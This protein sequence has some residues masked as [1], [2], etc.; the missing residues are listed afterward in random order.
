MPSSPLGICSEVLPLG[1]PRILEV[2]PSLCCQPF[3]FALADC[4][5]LRAT[6]RY[7]DRESHH[8]Y[9]CRGPS[10][11]PQLGRIY[12]RTFYRWLWC[13]HRFSCRPCLCVGN[14]TP[15]PSGPHDSY[16]QLLLVYRRHTGYVHP[17][18]DVQIR[19]FDRMAHSYMA[20]TGQRGSRCVS[21]FVP[22]RGKYWAL[23]P[24]WI[25]PVAHPFASLLDG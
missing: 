14:G 2:S 1:L 6:F 11:L 25:V 10:D 17:V 18:C 24:G 13:R 23:L 8:D 21:L 7:V 15:S 20:T 4:Q 3:A 16:L 12:V 5:R 22:A 9:R 19:F